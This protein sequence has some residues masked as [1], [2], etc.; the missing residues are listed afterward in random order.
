MWGWWG[1]GWPRASFSCLPTPCSSK[2]PPKSWPGAAA[3]MPLSLCPSVRPSTLRFFGSCSWIVMFWLLSAPAWG[4]QLHVLSSSTFCA[5]GFVSHCRFQWPV[6]I[7]LPCSLYLQDCGR[8]IAGGRSQTG[9]SAHTS[10]PIP[11]PPRPQAPS[12]CE[13]VFLVPPKVPNIAHVLLLRVLGNGDCGARASVP[14]C[15]KE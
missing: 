7:G 12:G 10:L 6:D 9:S 14:C 8:G 15:L 5:Q 4:V 13:V 2:A 11:G 1:V 3:P